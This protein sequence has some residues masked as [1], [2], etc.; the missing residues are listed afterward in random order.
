VRTK[1]P[2]LLLKNKDVTQGASGIFQNSKS[3]IHFMIF[4]LRRINIYMVDLVSEV[5][6]FMENFIELA[7]SNSSDKDLRPAVLTLCANLKNFGAQLEINCKGNLVLLH[8]SPI[9]DSLSYI[10]V[11][12]DQLDRVF[13]HLRNAGRDDSLDKVSRLH[14]L[15]VVELRAGRWS[16]QEQVNNY[17]QSKFNE[18]VVCLTYNVI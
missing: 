8:I 3:N 9:L 18:L 12:S 11:F 10:F 16:A 6:Q 17:Y 13:I 14:L 1:N 15:E 7:Q 4:S 2:Q 5:V